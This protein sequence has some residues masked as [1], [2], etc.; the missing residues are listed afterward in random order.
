MDFRWIK[1]AALT[2]LVAG[3]SGCG[4]ASGLET[5]ARLLTQPSCSD[6]FFPIYFNGKSAEVPGAARRLAWSAGLRSHGCRVEQVKVVGL[7]GY[8]EPVDASL[9]LS[10]DRA[11]KVAEMLKADGFPEPVFQLSP[12]GDVGADLAETKVP[13]RRADVYV[14]FAR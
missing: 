13:R 11:M 3:L 2:G 10:R 6:F 14:R 9:A 5:Q 12:L 7:P 1:A 8:E 4:T